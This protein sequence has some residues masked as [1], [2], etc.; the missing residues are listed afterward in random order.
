MKNKCIDLNIYGMTCSACV[1]KVENELK[2]VKGVLDVSV[3]LATE[4]VKIFVD[5]AKI[6]D[7]ISAVERI[8]YKA[9][10]KLEDNQYLNKELKI[11]KIKL[12]FGSIVSIILILSMLHELGL[13]FIPHSLM[14]PYF[15]L[16]ITIPVQFWVGSKFIIGA[17]K[18]FLNKTFDMNTLV[19]LGTLSAF[20]FSLIATLFP[21]IFLKNNIPLNYYYESSAVIIVLVLFGKFFE[22]KAKNKTS[23]AIKSLINLQ[24]KKAILIKDGKEIEIDIKELKV[25]DIVIVKPGQKIPSDGVIIKGYGIIDESMIN[26]ESIPIEKKVGDKV[27]GA[28]INING[29]FEMKVT[30]VGEQTLISQIIKLVENT[31]STKIPVQKIVDKVTSIFV[32]IIILVAVVT[33]LI[34]F[35]YFNNITLAFLNS[36]SVLVIACPCAMGLATPTA[37][38]VGVGRAAQSGILIN[39]LESLEILGKV[40]CIVTDKTGTLTV[41]KPEIKDIISFS[42]KENDILRIVASLEKNSEHPLSYSIL[43]RAKEKNIE[44]FEIEYFENVVGEGIGAEIN[45]IEYY[46]GNERLMKR[47]RININKEYKDMYENILSQGKTVMYLCD[48]KEIIALISVSDTIKKDA[49]NLINELSKKGIEIIMITGDNKKISEIIANELGISK[50]YYE[51]PPNEKSEYIRK[52]QK[53]GKIVAMLGDGINDAPALSQADVGIAMGNGSDIAIESSDITIIKGDLKKV[54]QILYLGSK[55]MKTIK[56]NLFWAFI[57]NIIFIPI[58]AG[59]FYKFNI[60]LTP[61]FSAFAMSISSISVLLN[62]LRLKFNKKNY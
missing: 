25:S 46:F 4:K 13:S 49:K 33:F 59:V 32:P 53:E 14:N 3:N 1:N 26:G 11:T 55:I 2:K 40:N 45:S 16:I 44:L 6:E 54:T 57:Y 9:S 10:Y 43:K 17:W 20:T 58:A 24:V 41:G 19:S 51:V 15:Q 23:E 30:K 22:T 12:V 47:K 48:E 29:S 52:L 61:I 38:V 7:L 5:D 56:Q 60:R 31:Q 21:N 8:G 39:N 28:T 50:F 37:I 62:S 42:Y 18:S 35:L 34:W 36:I 27:I